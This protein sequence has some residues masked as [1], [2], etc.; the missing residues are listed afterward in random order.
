MKLSEQCPVKPVKRGWLGEI[1]TSVLRESCIKRSAG[2]RDVLHG[3]PC[4]HYG[5]LYEKIKDGDWNDAEISVA[6]LYEVAFMKEK[7]CWDGWSYRN[8]GCGRDGCHRII[9]EEGKPEVFDVVFYRNDGYRKCRVHYWAEKV[10]RS[11]T[12]FTGLVE[13]PTSGFFDVLYAADLTE[14]EREMDLADKLRAVEVYERETLRESQ[15]NGT[16]ETLLA[17][18]HISHAFFDDD[19]GVYYDGVYFGD[20]ECIIRD[21]R[22]YEFADGKV[23]RR[24]DLVDSTIYKL[25]DGKIVD[26]GE[27]Y[28]HS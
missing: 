22:A 15:R 4:P 6:I 16:V 9:K 24:G 1:N 23:F 21:T 25:V 3:V 26:G 2:Y 13:D 14:P 10:E 20:D 27:P 7:N 11:W 8:T 5:R 28:R 12:I 19:F 17:E 18:A